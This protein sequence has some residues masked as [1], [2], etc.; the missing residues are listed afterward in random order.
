MNCSG[1]FCFFAIISFEDGAD[2]GDAAE[3]ES[4]AAVVAYGDCHGDGG[5]GEELALVSC[6][7]RSP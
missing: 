7:L 2:C 5:Q 1:L 3:E 4:A 6:A